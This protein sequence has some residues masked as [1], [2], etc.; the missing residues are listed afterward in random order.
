MSHLRC[1][2]P[3]IARHVDVGSAC[4]DK[5]QSPQMDVL[6]FIFDYWLKQ[7]YFSINEFKLLTP[8]VWWTLQAL[9]QHILLCV[10]PEEHLFVYWLTRL[11]SV[12]YKCLTVVIIMI[13]M[14]TSLLYVVLFQL[15]WRMVCCQPY[16][17]GTPW[18]LIVFSVPCLKTTD[19]FRL[20]QGSWLVSI[21]AVKLSTSTMCG[22]VIM[23]RMAVFCDVVHMRCV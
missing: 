8:L 5:R 17:P 1:T 22:L 9:Y 20:V 2:I 16:V 4:M 23:W 15:H 6:F 11:L 10:L 12:C 13:S 21:A 7:Q 14:L 19:C 18:R 3:E